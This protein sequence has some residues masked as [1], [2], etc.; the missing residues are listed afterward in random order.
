[1]ESFIFFSVGVTRVLDSS[2]SFTNLV[3]G[4]FKVFEAHLKC[5]LRFPPSKFL[6][7]LVHN[8][9]LCV[10]QFPLNVYVHINGFLVLCGAFMVKPQVST[11]LQY[12]SVVQTE[13]LLL[14]HSL[15][16]TGTTKYDLIFNC[17]DSWEG[18]H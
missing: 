5:G 2:T 1:M 18:A 15:R 12:Y 3:R 8:H 17:K 9:K 14:N 4:L 6:L 16:S 13:G 10:N 7:Q 11:F